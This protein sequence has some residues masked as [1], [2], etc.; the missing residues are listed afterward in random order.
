MALRQFIGW[1]G[2]DNQSDI[3]VMLNMQVFPSL[4]FNQKYLGNYL[5]RKWNKNVCIDNALSIFTLEAF[6]KPIN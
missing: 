1:P 2:E 5:F 6:A 4:L 3:G